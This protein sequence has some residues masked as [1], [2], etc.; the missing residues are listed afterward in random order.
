M[1]QCVANQKEQKAKGYLPRLIIGHTSDDPNA[2]EMPVAA[3][4]DNY[5]YNPR[6]KW[7][8]ADYVDVPE[9]LKN[10]IEANK[11]PGRSAEANRR[12]PRVEV[13]ALLGGT[14]P[15]FKLPDLKYAAA[16]SKVFIF[17]E[18]HMA[19]KAKSEMRVLYEDISAMSKPADPENPAGPKADPAADD[20]QYAKFCELMKRFLTKAFADESDYAE[21]D[22]TT[23]PENEKVPE[24][25]YKA[26]AGQLDGVDHDEPEYKAAMA[27]MREKGEIKHSA[28]S[29]G[30]NMQKYAELESRIKA[31]DARI[32][33]LL[34][35]VDKAEADKVELESKLER[36]DWTAKYQEKRI[37]KGRIDIDAN[38]ELLMGV[39]RDD[40]QKYFDQ[41]IKNISAPST[42]PVKQ[43]AGGPPVMAGS[44]EEAYA[45][46]EYY[47]A[48]K[49][50]LNYSFSAAQ[51]KYREE[52]GVRYA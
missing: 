28:K 49:E 42:A 31:S 38:V 10:Q 47:E 40:R 21:K 32:T 50:K 15:Y 4:L 52:K 7:L 44:E 27:R 37:P 13:V 36:Q 12:E 8:Y 14:P 16:D 30:E 2:P 22:D 1:Y 18:C 29:Q 6:D 3:Y 48:N 46:K 9:D 11:W 24:K 33:G 17:S 45:I 19:I 39:K 23:K 5:T 51:K 43:E 25:D 20:A 34:A 26:E 41:S 35:R